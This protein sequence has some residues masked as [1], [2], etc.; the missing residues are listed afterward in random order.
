MAKYSTARDGTEYVTFSDGMSYTKQDLEDELVREKIKLHFD[1]YK[2]LVEDS[3]LSCNADS[4]LKTAAYTALIAELHRVDIKD[5]LEDI[6][7]SIENISTVMD[8]CFDKR[9]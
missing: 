8:Y 3:G 7:L 4:L 6:S 1:F 5:C 9:D 2:K